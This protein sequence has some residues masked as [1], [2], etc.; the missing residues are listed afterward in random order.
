MCDAVCALAAEEL[1]VFVDMGS[2]SGFGK[3]G[4]VHGV[5]KVYGSGNICKCRDDYS[6]SNIIRKC[7]DSQMLGGVGE[8]G[9]CS[10]WAANGVLLAFVDIFL[11]KGIV[12]ELEYVCHDAVTL[13]TTRAGVDG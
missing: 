9:S 4:V 7:R 8:G 1:I 10:K 5:V 11:K 6:G 2:Q 12:C 3:M 13:E